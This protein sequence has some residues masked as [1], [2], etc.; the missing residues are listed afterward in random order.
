MFWKPIAGGDFRDYI[1]DHADLHRYVG[2][3]RAPHPTPEAVLRTDQVNTE[4]AP[5]DRFREFVWRSTF[6]DRHFHAA[7]QAMMAFDEMLHILMTAASRWRLNLPRRADNV[8]FVS[9]RTYR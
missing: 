5:T 9:G 6:E 1:S 7:M 8:C 2:E 3:D 4:Y